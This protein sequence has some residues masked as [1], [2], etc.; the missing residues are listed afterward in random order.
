MFK[1]IVLGTLLIGLIGVLVAGAIIRT[2]DKTENVAEA[3]GLGQGRSASEAGE[4]VS[5]GQGQGQGRGRSAQGTGS[6]QSAGS[7]DR[8]YPN[9]DEIPEE[10]GLYEGTVLLSPETGGDLVIMTDEG[11]EITVGTG[12][13]YMEEQ[14][15][16]LQAGE[17]VQVQGYWE[18]G[19][20]KAAQLTRLQ[21]GQTITLRDQLGRPEWAGSGNRAAEQQVTTAGG[22]RFSSG[23]SRGSGYDGEGRSDAPGDG[24]GTG[25]AVVDEWLTLSGTV[26]SVDASLLA[27]QLD[28]GELVEMIGRPWTFAQEQ[29]FTAEVGDRVTVVGFYEGDELEVG[30]IDNVSSGLGVE[31]REESGRPLWAGRGRRGS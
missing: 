13:G 12:P 31:I 10:M 11:Q 8:L 5:Q 3:R 27:V 17:Q 16:V 14:G 21:D 15:F 29:G 4:A 2:V 24:T 23:E 30:Q 28:N 25:Q 26:I 9:Y 7:T 19:E 6:G 20:L 1:R 18:D 22:G